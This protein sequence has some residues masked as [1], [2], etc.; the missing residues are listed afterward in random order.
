MKTICYYGQNWAGNVGNA[1]IDYSIKYCLKTVL[2]G[3][4]YVIYE[5]S[6]MPAN[7]KFNFGERKPFKWF[8]RETSKFDLRQHIKP[9]YVVLGG[10]LFDV[11]WT[12]MHASFLNWLIERKIRVIILGG[13]GGNHYSQE[14]V[15]Y[16]RNVW[17]QINVIGYIAR[18]YRAYENFKDLFP[19]HY[20]GIDN[21]FFLADFFKP[22][23]LNIENLGA[24]AFDLTFDREVEFPKDY[25][26]VTLR[27]RVQDV[28]S[29]KFFCK[30]GIKTWTIGA[31]TDVMS[32]CP[33]DYLHIYG[34]SKITHSDRVHA[35]VSTLSFGGKAQYYDKSD[36][37]YLFE[38]IGLGN[39]NKELVQLDQKYIQEEKS[40]QLTFLKELID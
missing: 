7:L 5:A 27:H 24:K 35:C 17:K 25:T 20:A 15:S 2:E 30:H 12:R 3:K 40:K 32:D 22:A 34:N 23:K 26:V 6:N 1:F 37:S 4:E 36:R 21:A 29:F 14:E 19:N 31:E 8:C 28:D 9:D 13:G 33:E 38:R 10:S 11:F 18:D 16:V 39:I